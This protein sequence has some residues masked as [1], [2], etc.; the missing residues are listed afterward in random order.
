V[1]YLERL[2][3]FPIE[4]LRA[5]IAARFQE[6]ADAGASAVR[7]DGHVWVFGEDE[8][9]PALITVHARSES[10]EG[11]IRRVRRK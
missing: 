11:H 7:A 2:G 6:A 3:G 8:F 9:G 4:E 1:R 5:Q 10:P